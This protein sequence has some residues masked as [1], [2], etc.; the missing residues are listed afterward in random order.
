MQALV[1][2]RLASLLAADTKQRRW[3]LALGV[4]LS[5]T[6]VYFLCAPRQLWTEHTQFN[7]FAL[8]ADAWL[9]GRL[10]LGHPPPAYTQNN[11]FAEVQGRYYVSFPPFPAVLLLPFAKLAGSPENLRD[12]QIWLWLAGVGPAVLFLVLEKLRRLGES[13][14]SDIEHLAL[15]WIFAFGT[16]Y[17]FTAEQGTVWFAALVVAVAL[18]A[19][20]LLAALDAEHPL[21]AGIAT[22][23]L[24][25]TRPHVVLAGS[26]FFGFEV[27]KKTSGGSA[28]TIDWRMASKKLAPFAIPILVVLVATAWHNRARYG[29]FEFGHEHLTVGWRARIDKWGL[30]SYHYLARNLAIVTSSLPYY[31]RVPP[32][33]QINTH[34]LALWFTTPIYLWLLWPRRVSF[35]WRAL[36][37]SIVPV[38]LVDLLYQNSGWLQFGYRFS[39]D[40]AVFLFAMLAIGGYKFG[41]LFYALAAWG[42]VV[43]GFG[44]LTFER[45][46]FERFYFT[47][48]SQQTIFQP[49]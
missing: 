33:F 1:Q 29:G 5:C 40:F 21:I 35:R 7:H 24:L 18:S 19:V 30:I 47:D 48:G 36:V 39:N 41:R 37:A 13:K 26:I 10:D 32:R 2:E 16:V 3:V 15:A 4:Y 42:V 45:R 38:L 6:V 44:A 17:F 20:F 43:N 9:H 11:D 8:L 34:G 25:V 46:G 49:D 31:N 23:L 12:G 14:H 22:A 28:R 27:W